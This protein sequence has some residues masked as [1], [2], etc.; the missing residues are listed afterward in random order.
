M[1]PSGKIER[2][3]AIFASPEEAEAETRQ[4]YREMTPNERVALTVALQRRYYQRRAPGGRLQ[5]ILT[6]LDRT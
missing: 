6:V 1:N 3:L 5:R 4:R 2:T